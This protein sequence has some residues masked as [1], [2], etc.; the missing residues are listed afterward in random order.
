MLRCLTR[1]S[2]VAVVLF[3]MAGYAGCS[4]DTESDPTPG[5][6]VA[7]TPDTAVEEDLAQVDLQ[8]QPDAK[9]V[10]VPEDLATEDVP[11]PKDQGTDQAV[12][13]EL[14][15]DEQVEDPWAFCD[16]LTDTNCLE[17]VRGEKTWYQK[18]DRHPTIQFDDEGTP[19]TVV[20]LSDLI[21]SDIAADPGLWRY[22]IFGTDGFT[23]G[24]F[25]TWD[26]MMQGYMELGARRV[27]WEPALELPD[28]WRVKDSYQIVL[29][30]AGE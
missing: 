18:L 15:P 24:G 11:D 1:G 17:I 10:A 25:A 6:D 9:D 20:R 8:V 26:Q 28:S 13:P 2:F 5:N 7:V 16:A 23:F 3:L 4:S 22:Q 21:E 30:P 27:V 14:V 12:E 19:R 29:S